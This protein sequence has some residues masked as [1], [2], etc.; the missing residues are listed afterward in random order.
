MDGRKWKVKDTN[1]EQIRLRVNGTEDGEELR[2]KTATLKIKI[3]SVALI[4]EMDGER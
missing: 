1:C 2:L 3:N 4:F